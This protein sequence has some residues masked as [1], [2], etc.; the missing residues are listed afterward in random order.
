[1]TR[2]KTVS[3]LVD[4]LLTEMPEF[5]SYAQ[6]VPKAYKYQRQLLRGLMNLRPSRPLN[7]DFVVL[8]DE[9][10]QEELIDKQVIDVLTLPST[11]YPKIGLFQGDITRLKCDA[12][13]N[14]AN[15]RM[16]GCFVPGHN[17]IDN[18]IH[19]AAGLQMREECHQI[20][21]RQG[22]EETVGHAQITK[23]YNLPCRYVIHTVGPTIEVRPTNQDKNDLENCYISCL[24]IA[25]ANKI[26]TIVFPCL[27]TGE[28]RYP[29]KE[30]ASVAVD[31]VDY[32][33]VGHENAPAV[34]FDVFRDEDLKYYSNLLQ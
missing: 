6:G 24:D 22:H 19:S 17:C 7:H 9:L 27:S 13:V 18:C 31:T 15:S 29:Q 30:A 12:I 2:E 5:L 20:I 33:L 32:Y 26:K 21:S 16:L 34:I 11:S 25:V 10:L 23:G 1:V 3:T 4:W 28:F 8:Q 14:A